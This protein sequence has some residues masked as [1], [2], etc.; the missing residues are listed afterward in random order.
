MSLFDKAVE[1]FRQTG[2]VHCVHRATGKYTPVPVAE[3]LAEKEKWNER[4]YRQF[5]A[6]APAQALS[7]S[8]IYG[9][10]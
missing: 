6:A 1:E 4:D 9:R 8:M 3:Y 2:W 5:L 7:R 10:N